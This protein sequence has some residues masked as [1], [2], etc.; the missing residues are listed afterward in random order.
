MAFLLDTNVVSETVRSRPAPEVLDWL[1]AQMPEDLFLTSIGV[2]ELLR[3]ARKLHDPARRLHFENWIEVR[4]T[5]QFEGRILPFDLPAARIW[6]AL[7]G[8]GDRN[9]RP[10]AVLDAQIG[11]IA[12]HRGLT[13]V[14]RNVKDFSPMGMPVHNPWTGIVG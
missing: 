11:A 14:T 2:G 6:G 12:I 9:G 7:V 8:D 10:L 5:A 1:A 3:G 4:L 13:V